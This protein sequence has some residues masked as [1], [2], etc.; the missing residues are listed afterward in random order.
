MTFKIVRN[1]FIFAIVLIFLKAFY[2]DAWY[3]AKYGDSNTSQEENMTQEVVQESQDDDLAA[4]GQG[5]Q[6]V[7]PEDALTQNQG[8][9]SG[10]KP[11]T[12]PP[13]NQTGMNDKEKMPIDKFGDSIASSLKGKITTPEKKEVQKGGF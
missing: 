2:F 12:A 11:D 4:R 9:T 8:G 7:D 6:K 5:I 3:K 13:V 1:L 10:M